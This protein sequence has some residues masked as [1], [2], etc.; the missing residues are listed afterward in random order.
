MSRS[1][2]APSY[3]VKETFNLMKTK[4]FFLSFHLIEQVRDFRASGRP[5]EMVLKKGVD[6]T[7][8]HESHNSNGNNE[9][10][11]SIC[12]MHK[13]IL[14][15]ESDIQKIVNLTEQKH[16]DHRGKRPPE[17]TEQCRENLP[18]SRCLCSR[19]LG[20]PM[21]PSEA[22]WLSNSSDCFLCLHSLMHFLLGFIKNHVVCLN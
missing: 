15:I 13:N 17:K 21:M 22:P 19:K 14:H 18:L 16:L 3:V 10:S 1:G 2:E 7:R 6:H 5:K 4:E 12:Y 9:M 8:F 11:N 20:G